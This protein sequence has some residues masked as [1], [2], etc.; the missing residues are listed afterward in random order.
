MTYKYSPRYPLISTDEHDE[1]LSWTVDVVRQLYNDR[2]KRFN[3]IPE[4][5][6]TLANASVKPGTNSQ[7]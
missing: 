3:E 2:L 6:G 4:D 5:Q 1:K 7:R